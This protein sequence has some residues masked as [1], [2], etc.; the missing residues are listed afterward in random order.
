MADAISMDVL[1]KR[2]K[3]LYENHP[4]IHVNINL[5]HPKLHLEN[6]PATIVGVYPNIFVVSENSKG[7]EEKHTLMYTDVWIGHI[8][9][10]ELK[11][12]K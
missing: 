4:N 6:A 12:F 8:E 7:R 3:W 9:I 10:L 1:K 2:I 5:N 11:K